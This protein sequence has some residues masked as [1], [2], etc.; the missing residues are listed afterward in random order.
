MYRADTATATFDGAFAIK[1][2]D[3]NIGEGE[4]TDLSTIANDIQIKFHITAS[5][6]K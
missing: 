3:Y 6:R 5:P 2:L 4:W 1:R